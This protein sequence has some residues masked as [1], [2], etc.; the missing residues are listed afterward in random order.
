MI[1]FARAVDKTILLPGD[2]LIVL[3]RRRAESTRADQQHRL[4]S[5]TV[6]QRL[7]VDRVAASEFGPPHR[8]YD[9]RE[10]ILLVVGDGCAIS[11][12]PP[13]VEPDVD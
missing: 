6:E 1:N 2:E 12:L 3:V 11:Y 4:F 5:A 7:A 9:L 8:V 10:G 13:L